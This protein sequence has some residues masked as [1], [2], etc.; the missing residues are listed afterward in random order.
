MAERRKRSAVKQARRSA[1]RK[2]AHQ[3]G[4]AES[5][6]ADEAP[7]LEEVRAA[8]DNAVPLDLLGLVSTVIAATAPPQSPIL[9]RP[10]EENPTSLAELVTA[11]IGVR[12]PETT[13]LLAALRELV[14]DDVLHDRCRR[15]VDLR[16]DDLPGWLAD[17]AET[18]VVEVVRMT[19]VLGDGDELL[20]GVRFADGQEMTG[21]VF[22]DHLANSAVRD[23]FFVPSAIDAVLAVA[24]GS[25][26]DPDTTFVDMDLAAARATLGMALER[27]ATMF[28][29][30]ESDTWPATRA[31]VQWLTRLLPVESSTLSVQQRDST[32]EFDV[33]EQFFASLVGM[34]FDR[35]GHRALL[36]QHSLEGTGDPVRWSAARLRMQLGDE[37]AYDDTVA[38]GTHLELPELLRAYVPFA[39]AASGIRQE[40]TVEALAA[41]DETA[42]EYRAAVVEGAQT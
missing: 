26:T 34:P 10:P 8:L 1:R 40:L 17:L 25:N 27:H 11:F 15:E 3:R 5:Q 14:V 31:L 2:K 24:Q 29:P 20:L 35:P 32:S 37:P 36:L 22:V 21:C 16:D 30:E 42:D 6:S 38:L 39:H 4:F 9:L 41:I 23:A 13:A 7:L 18:S 19:H 12:A 33:L 28:M